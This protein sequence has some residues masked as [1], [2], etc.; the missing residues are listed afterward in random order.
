MYTEYPFKYISKRSSDSGITEVTEGIIDLLL[1]FDDDGIIKYQPYDYKSN[2]KNDDIPIP[3]FE[4]HLYSKYK[5]QFELYKKALT[6]M[7]IG[8]GDGT[9][10]VQNVEI[11]PVK[12]YHLYR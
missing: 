3:Q 5:G 9:N 4:A 1:V 12:L 8:K 7:L 11:L 10:N 6:D 2:E